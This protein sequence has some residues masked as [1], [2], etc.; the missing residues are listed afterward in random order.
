[1]AI[2][3]FQAAPATRKVILGVSITA[4][5]AFC[6]LLPFFQVAAGM[7]L[8]VAILFGALWIHS[9][10]ERGCSFCHRPKED[11]RHLIPG[12]V[13]S[14]CDECLSS[15]LS[16]LHEKA[17]GE[18]AVH[19][20]RSIPPHLPRAA[21]NMLFRTEQ[22][23]SVERDELVAAALRVEDDETVV[24]VTERVPAEKRTLEDWLHLSVSYEELGRY[25]D[26]L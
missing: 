13:A 7:S 15:G 26:A 12:D 24:T 10:P 9:Q 20:L 6:L 2:T 5:I 11:V 3:L 21:S 25:D 18:F 4:A 14:I 22:N 19:I 1:M 16:D 8:I 23:N 17:P